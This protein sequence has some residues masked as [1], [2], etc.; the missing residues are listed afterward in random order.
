MAANKTALT[1]S[2]GRTVRQ[3]AQEIQQLAVVPRSPH[4]RSLEVRSSTLCQ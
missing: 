3:L 1:R 2:T 4:C